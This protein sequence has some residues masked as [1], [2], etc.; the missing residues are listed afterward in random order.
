MF[1]ASFLTFIWIGWGVVT[2]AFVVLMI[3]KSVVGVP[4]D[5]FVIF[6]AAQRQA[7]SR[8]RVI[9][10]RVDR[11]TRLAKYCGCASLGLL[12][13]SGAVWVYRGIVAVKGGRTPQRGPEIEPE[14]PGCCT[15][16]RSLVS[17]TNCSHCSPMRRPRRNPRSLRSTFK[18]P[19]V[20][21]WGQCPLSA[22]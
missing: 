11:F 6:G 10:A 1:G 15:G 14:C 9:V 8:H 7:E 17:S 22:N 12:L 2:A 5:S 18:A 4:E 3:W 16:K 20:A 13:I 19:V 21:Y